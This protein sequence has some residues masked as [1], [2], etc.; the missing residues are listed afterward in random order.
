MSIWKLDIWS[1]FVVVAVVR[2]L[3]MEWNGMEWNM[4]TATTRKN[5]TCAYGHMDG[6]ISYLLENTLKPRH[7]RIYALRGHNREF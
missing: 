5:P 4:Y 3:H 2:V 1:V 6:Y 7:A